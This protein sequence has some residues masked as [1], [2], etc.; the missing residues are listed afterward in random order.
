ME[1]ELEDIMSSGWLVRT[2]QQHRI[3][4]IAIQGKRLG[5]DNAKILKKNLKVYFRNL[6]CK[7]IFILI[8]I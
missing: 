8:S 3:C 7:K 2:E 1:A 5:G 6:F 4:E